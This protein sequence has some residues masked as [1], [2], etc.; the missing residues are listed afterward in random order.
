MIEED[1]EL[2]V[3]EPK[4]LIHSPQLSFYLTPDKTQADIYFQLQINHAAREGFNGG[5]FMVTA[6]RN[7]LA[8]DEARSTFRDPLSADGEQIRWTSAMAVIDGSLL[9]AIKD[10][11][12]THWGNFGG[13][14]YILKMPANSIQSLQNY[15]PLHSVESMDIGFGANRVRSVLLKKSRAYYT[16]GKVSEVLVNAGR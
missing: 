7:D 13:P 11:T 10:G 4:P 3:T 8:Y 16:D 14:E 12:G 9:F 6:I 15:S 1:W 5:G 2:S